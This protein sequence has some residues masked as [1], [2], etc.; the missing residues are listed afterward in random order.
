MALLNEQDRFSRGQWNPYGE[1]VVESSDAR[2]SFL[3]AVY[4]HMALGLGVTGV[5]AMWTAHAGAFEMV[6]QLRWLLIIAQL[7][8]VLGLS[9]FLGRLSVAAATTMF[10]VY[11]ALTGLLLSGIF[12]AYSG[13]SIATTFFVTGGTFGAM[14]LYGTVTKRDLSGMGTFFLMALIGVI[15][16]SLVNF[17]LQSTAL[18]WITTY[19]GLFIFVGLTAYD[20]QRIQRMAYLAE[21]GDSTRKMAINGALALYLDFIN[22]FLYLLRIFGRRR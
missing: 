7:G 8:L 14:S 20:T 11:A 12:V 2:S 9:A 18:M 10:Y 5:V 3:N 16:A 4:R 15:L 22:M 21:P 6:Y 17:F 19:L 13:E 1:A